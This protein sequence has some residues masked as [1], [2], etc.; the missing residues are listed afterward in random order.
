MGRVHCAHTTDNLECSDTPLVLIDCVLSAP[1]HLGLIL[2]AM[3]KIL[4]YLYI[5]V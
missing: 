2:A 5:F 1:M 4:V 3:V